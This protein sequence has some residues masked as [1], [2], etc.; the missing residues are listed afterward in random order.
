MSESSPHAPATTSRAGRTVHDGTAYVFDEDPGSSSASARAGLLE[1]L[2]RE[3]LGPAEGDTELL[4][5]PP[6]QRYLLGRIAPTRLEDPAEARTKETSAE[7]A[8]EG[9]DPLEAAQSTGVPVVGAEEETLGATAEED[10]GE[11]TDDEPVRRGLMIP[12]SMGLRFQVPADLDALTVHISWGTYEPLSAETT[13]SAGTSGDSRYRRVPHD[14]SLSLELA[15]LTP[16]AT[17]D[18]ALE[19]EVTLRIDSHHDE[20]ADRY[21]I[22]LALCNDRTTPR[23]IPTEAWMFQTRI[24]VDAGG[25]AVFLPVHD[26]LVPPAPGGPPGPCPGSE[27]ARLDLQYR[28]RLEFAVGRTCSATWSLPPAP[29]GQA[30][31]RRAVQVRTTWIPTAETPQTTAAHVPGAQLDMRALA[32]AATAPDSPETLRAALQPI[33]EAYSSWLDGQDTAA[34]ALPE[35]V[36]DTAAEALVEARQVRDQ[37]ADGLAHLTADTPEGAEARRSFAFMNRVMADQRLRSQVAAARAADPQ[38]SVEQ[39][40]ER[41]L[42][43]SHPHHWRVFQLAFILMQ[44]PALTDPAAQ[45]RCGPLAAVELLFFPTGGGKTEAYLGL[46]AYA[47]AIRRRQGLLDT[48]DGPLDGRAGVTVLMRY[49]LRLLTSQQFQRA[50]TL[51][52]AAELARREDPETWGSEPF[53]IGLWVGTSVSPKRVREAAEELQRLR[54]RQGSGAGYRFSALQLGHCPWCGLALSPNDVTVGEAAGMAERV[55]VHCPD[56]YGECP[57]SAGDDNVPDGL[58]VLTTDEEIYRL[59]PAFVI[60]TV[61]KLA[62]LARE[63]HAATLFG[64]VSR[65]CERH[66]YVPFR[67]HLDKSDYACC[68]LADNGRHNATP[69]LPASAIRPA[70]RLRPPDLIIQDELHLITGALGT[71]VGLFETAVETMCAWTA[72]DGRPAAPLIVASSATVRRVA[73]QVR[74]LYGRDVTIFPPQV[75][76]AADTFFSRALPVDAE[77]PGRL[78]VGLSTTGVRLTAA[79]IQVTQVLMS[80]AQLLLDRLGAAADPYMTLVGYFSAT[81]ELA[82]MARYVQDDIQTGLAKPGGD[83]RLPRRRGT[84]FGALHLGELTSRISSADITST[85]DRMALTFDPEVDST[86]ARNAAVVAARTGTKVVRRPAEASPYDVVLATSML[87]VGVD[88]SRLGLMLVVGQPK[89]T[90]EYIQATSRVGRDMADRPGLVVTLGNWARP[91]DLAHYE[92]FRHFHET[93]YARVEP[94]SVTP[95]SVTAVDRGLDGALVAAARVT[96]AGTPGGL[97][98]ERDAGNA[99]AQ[100]EALMTLTRSLTARIGAAGGEDASQYASS[101]LDSRLSEWT[102]RARHAAEGGGTLVYERGADDARFFALLRSAESAGGHAPRQ[103]GEPFVVA[104]SM[105]EVQPEINLLVS[106]DPSR[107]VDRAAQEGPAWQRQETQGAEETEQEDGQ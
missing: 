23:R 16:G 85:L 60:A 52:C 79:E 34:E 38:L 30:P 41:V 28:D 86:A 50:T 53:R 31:T 78:Y 91:R 45:R 82:G 43:G 20:P 68:D 64:H 19:G 21:L 97:N 10:P 67:D 98:P 13:E 55:V 35:H 107:L 106:P 3:L 102:R 7:A 59:T 69:T 14:H 2:R 96:Q 18:R 57:F 26:P 103:D 25:R 105:R 87:Q 89:N 17:Q 33:I 40:Q 76:D 27:E 49:T 39:A 84:D 11:E 70:T 8:G 73:D 71:T 66:G 63:G 48:P 22:E 44:L 24:D 51:V 6:G 90:A 104:G 99:S 9:V 29:G 12:A 4:S 58:P 46:A 72:P 93:F 74:L 83:S 65:R 88:V 61:D 47:F 1:V 54:S 81:R 36:R 56:P 37:L 77:H 94:L 42:A 32:A 80:G 101:R 62:R 100:E 15:S 75:L 92:Q 5:S 95:F